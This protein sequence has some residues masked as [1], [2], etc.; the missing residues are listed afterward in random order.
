MRGGA[1]RPE[2]AQD[3]GLDLAAQLVVV[4]A[5]ERGRAAEGGRFGGGVGVTRFLVRRGASVLVTDATAADQLSESVA[6]LAGL[7]V[8]LR[9]AASTLTV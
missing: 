4:Q 7:P 8:E 9:L 5:G 2:V 3:L 6:Q 1:G